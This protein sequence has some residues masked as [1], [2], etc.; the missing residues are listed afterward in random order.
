M[1]IKAYHKELKKEVNLLEER[2]K[3]DR[4]FMGW[5]KIREAKKQKLKAK[6]RLNENRTIKSNT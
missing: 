4:G 2:R 6:E 1:S 5:F 3:F